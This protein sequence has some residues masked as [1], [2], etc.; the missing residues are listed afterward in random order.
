MVHL[1]VARNRDV[2][3]CLPVDTVDL[4]LSMFEKC[5]DTEEFNIF[6]TTCLLGTT[7][8]ISNCQ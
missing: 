3:F 8:K 7:S 6:I 4:Y 1:T 2:S 5:V